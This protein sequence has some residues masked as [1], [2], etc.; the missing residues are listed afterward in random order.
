MAGGVL[1]AE[2]GDLAAEPHEPVGVLHR[3]LEREGEL[4]DAIFDEIRRGLVSVGVGHR[5]PGFILLPSPACYGGSLFSRSLTASERAVDRWRRPRACACLEAQAKP[6]ARHALLR[7]G[8]CRD[9]AARRVLSARHR[10]TTPRWHGLQ[11]EADR[12]RGHRPRSAARR[13]PCRR[14]RSARH[15]SVRAVAGSSG[16][17]GSKG[18]TKDLC[19]RRGYSDSRLSPLR[20]CACGQGLIVARQKLPIVVKADGLA[21]GKGVIIAETREQAEAAIE[22]CFFRRVRRGGNGSGDRGVPARRG[23]ELLRPGRRRRPPCRSPRRRTTSALLR[24]RSGA[25]TPAAWAPIRRRRS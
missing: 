16:L 1:A 25:R 17:E 20:R 13:G 2:A 9:R 6:A 4:R 18:F 24:R 10:Q 15:Q 11:G 7:A 21:A 22:A 19:A 12:P 5:N 23:G 14:S 3:P 8:Q